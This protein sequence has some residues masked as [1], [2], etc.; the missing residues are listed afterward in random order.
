MM[1]AMQMSAQI[2]FGPA[3]TTCGTITFRD[4]HQET[5]PYVSLPT[6]WSENIFY[7]DQVAPETEGK[8]KAKK[9][10]SKSYPASDIAYV[11]Y[12]A[13]DFPENKNTIYCVMIKPDDKRNGKLFPEWG[14]P[15][16]G[17]DRCFILRCV[18]RYFV[19]KKTGEFSTI[20][21]LDESIIALGKPQLEVW[22]PL[23]LQRFDSDHA[24]F[25]GN[26][27]HYKSGKTHERVAEYSWPNQ[28]AKKGAEVFK[29]YPEIQQQILDGTL[30]AADLQYI[31]DQI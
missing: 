29:D 26:I 14:I 7:S 16:M 13:Q 27:R 15:V 2:F 23:V 11:T 31:I 5:Y 1:M 21:T 8:K 10:K 30:K 17:N 18:D 19:A 12:W 25:V 22:Q 9:Q 6:K 3:A 20:V 4:G 28:K 24:I